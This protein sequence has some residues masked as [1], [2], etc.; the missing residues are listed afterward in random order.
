MGRLSQAAIN[1]PKLF[2]QA[3]VWSCGISPKTERKIKCND[4]TSNTKAFGKCHESQRDRELVHGEGT[5]RRALL[6]VGQPSEKETGFRILSQTC[7]QHNS[8]KL[9]TEMGDTEHTDYAQNNIQ[10]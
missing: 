8:E 6:T 5:V 9:C 3:R 1:S 4:W 2:L 7:M 10:N